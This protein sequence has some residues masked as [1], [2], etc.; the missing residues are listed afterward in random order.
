MSYEDIWN[1]FYEMLKRKHGIDINRRLSLLKR[2]R[3]EQGWS[4]SKVKKISKLDVITANPDIWKTIRVAIQIIRTR[5]EEGCIN[6][7]HV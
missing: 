2:R 3:I 7:G 1:S 4:D 5:W 6:N